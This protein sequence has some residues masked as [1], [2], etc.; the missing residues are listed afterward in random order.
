MVVVY[1]FVG[2]LYF[3]ATADAEENEV[4]LAQVLT[5]FV[6]TISLLLTCVSRPPA[7]GLCSGPRASACATW[8]S[9]CRVVASPPLLTPPLPL[10]HALQ[11][12]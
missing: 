2:D 1:K 9:H 6:D 12:G 4:I 5:T 10:F 11:R 8:G 7:A 3:Y